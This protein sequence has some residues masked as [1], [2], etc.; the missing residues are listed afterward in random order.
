MQL[1]FCLDGTF[2][3]VRLGPQW[4]VTPGPAFQQD[5]HRWRESRCGQEGGGGAAAQ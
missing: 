5:R 2:C 4:M 1:A 3:R